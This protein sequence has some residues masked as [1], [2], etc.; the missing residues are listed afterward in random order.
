M[1]VQ[2]AVGAVR[3]TVTEAASI[4]LDGPALLAES[5]TD[6]EARLKTTVPSEQDE[7]V[8][9]K[10]EPEAAFEEKEQPV[11]VPS[12]EKSLEVRPETAF[13]KVRV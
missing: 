1:E 13:E 11:A 10:D 9:V 7:A 6:P 3:S 8:T 5:E 12:F 4:L 2:V